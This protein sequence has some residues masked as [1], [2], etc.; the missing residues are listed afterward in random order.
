MPL[1]NFAHKEIIALIDNWTITVFDA[2]DIASQ[3]AVLVSKPKLKLEK[4]L[5]DAH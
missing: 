1:D 4:I 2:L 5:E 3:N